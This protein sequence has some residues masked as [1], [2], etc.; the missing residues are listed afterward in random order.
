M[1]KLIAGIPV[2]NDLKNFKEAINSFMK[3]TISYDYIYIIE[4]QSTDGTAEYCD[5]LHKK[6][7][8]K[9]FILKT[10]KLGPLHAYNEIFKQA[11]KEKADLFLFQS[12]VTFPKCHNRDWLKEMQDVSK[13]EECG[14]VTCYGGGGQSGPDFIDSFYWVGAWTT[15]IPYKTIKKIGGYDMNIPMGYG[16]DIDYSYAINQAGLKVYV[17]NYWVD[18]HPD[19]RKNHQHEKVDNFKEIIDSAFIY[20]RKKWRLGEF[21]E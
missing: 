7:P 10:P 21:K 18:H 15:C 9:I 8:D 20:M 16:V 4:S 12:D 19:Y 2:Y 1:N 3:S 14:I 5:K 13:L 11:K 17:I 6:Y